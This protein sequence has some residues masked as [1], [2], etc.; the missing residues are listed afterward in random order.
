MSEVRPRVVLG[1]LGE[2]D[3]V[4]FRGELLGLEQDAKDGCVYRCARSTSSA[5][6]NGSKSDGK[7]KE[8]GEEGTNPLE[9]WHSEG[10]P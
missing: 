2:L 4:D 3:E 5:S 7:R 9:L 8:V 6:Q 10:R 1:V